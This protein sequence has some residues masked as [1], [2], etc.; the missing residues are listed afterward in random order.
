MGPSLDPSNVCSTLSC[1][2]GLVK[3]PL[4]GLFCCAVYPSVLCVIRT[5]IR[6]IE[7]AWTLGV[8]LG[9]GSSCV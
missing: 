4:W 2:I 6:N 8:V 1:L 3:G 7:E 5:G 9:V